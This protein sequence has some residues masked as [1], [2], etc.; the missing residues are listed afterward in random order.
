MVEYHVGT[1]LES[2]LFALL[3]TRRTDDREAATFCPLDR[4]DP[5]AAACTMDENG[6]TFL[7]FYFLKQRPIRSR[8]WCPD[9]R[10]LF[11]GDVFRQRSEIV[12]VNYR[13]L[14][15]GTRYGVCRVDT[16]SG[17]PMFDLIS[18]GLN[19][20]GSIFARCIRQGWRC[21]VL[22]A[23]YVSLDRVHTD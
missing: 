1:L 6:L 11:E 23:A 19:D 16:I 17:M 15:V 22:P 7:S 2:Q 10:T 4:C 12:F 3:R 8:V 5:H 21:G 20:A 13:V 18:H 9:S 14:G